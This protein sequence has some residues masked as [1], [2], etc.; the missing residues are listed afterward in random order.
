[1]SAI[2]NAIFLEAVFAGM[3]PGSHTIICGFAGDP[4]TK[5]REQSRRNWCGRPWSLGDAVPAWF[6][7]ENSYYTVS[8]FE[9]DP[10][11]GEQRRRKS[12]FLQEK[13]GLA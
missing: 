8:T 6:D 5:D 12:E 1:M 11:T 4:N 3:L 13:R 10:Q 9:P 2:T 7:R